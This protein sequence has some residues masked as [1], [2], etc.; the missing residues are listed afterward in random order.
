M[1]LT[2]TDFIG[3]YELHKGMYDTAKLQI[4]INK[5]EI[6]YLKAML[7]VDL[8]NQFI[9]DLSPNPPLPQSPNFQKIFYAFA[10]DI[11]YNVLDSDGMLEMLKGFIYF[12][13]SKDNFMQQTT[14]GG[15][16]QTAENSKVLT[17]LQTMIYAR[18]NEAIRTYNA[19]QGYIILHFNQP[20][21]QLVQLGVVSAGFGYTAGTNVNAI[22]MSN[23]VAFFTGLSGGT[24]YTA[25][26]YATS[27]GTGT[28]LTLT[29]F[30]NGAG[31]ITSANM[32]VA[33]TGY[34]VGDVVSVLGGTGGTFTIT[35]VYP[36]SNGTGGQISYLSHN[37]GGIVSLNLQLGGQSF[38]PGTITNVNVIGGTG[39]GAKA[40]LTVNSAG[41]V[42]AIV[43][44]TEGSGYM[45]TQVVSFQSGMGFGCTANIA[46]TWNG[47]IY[48]ITIPT[49]GQDY[50]VGD[51]LGVPNPTLNGNARLICAY[52]GKG[53]YNLFK[54]LKKAT[55]YWI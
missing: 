42:T 36:A 37:V 35:Q 53:N 52:A 8:Y 1:F 13:Y 19:I 17:S 25:G 55:A 41:A 54:G 27:G 4:Y 31:A 14:Y 44:T 40:T 51:Y 24:G 26:T 23:S 29:I 45:G 15:V 16:Q 11:N 3:K 10:E 39:S 9:G 50:K 21:G 43:I 28:G 20:T 18:Y 47:E 38:T 2:P 5:Y 30:V 49:R 46:N 6:R 12:E 7:G 48:Q 33:G 34:T 22:T 32:G